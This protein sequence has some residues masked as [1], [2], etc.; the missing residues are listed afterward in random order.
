LQLSGEWGVLTLLPSRLYQLSFEVWQEPPAETRR[1]LGS[2]HRVLTLR[3]LAKRLAPG[4]PRDWGDAVWMPFWLHGAYVPRATWE[5][6]NLALWLE[7]KAG[8]MVSPRLRLDPAE[9]AAL[10]AR[11]VQLWSIHGPSDQVLLK[12]PG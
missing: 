4:Q 6:P 9:C 12:P 1:L 5:G 7:N 10:Y 2:T 3:W 11:V 8:E